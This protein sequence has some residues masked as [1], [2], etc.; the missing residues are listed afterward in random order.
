MSMSD[1]SFNIVP[2]GY[3]HCDSQYPAEVPRQPSWGNNKGYIEIKPEFQDKRLWHQLDGFSH[4]WVQFIFHKNT[5]W[6]PMTQPPYFEAEKVGTWASRSP[7]RPNRLGMSCLP[8]LKINNN[9]IFVEQ[10]DL[11]NGTPI[12]DIKPYVTQTDAFPDARMGWLQNMDRE[13][14]DV[15]IQPSATAKLTWLKQN[16]SIDFAGFIHT[17]LSHQPDDVRYKR[18]KKCVE[19]ENLVIS[20]RTWRIEYQIQD[21]KV[22]ILDISSGYTSQQ[23]S[24]QEDPIGDKDLHRK[25]L[26][27]EL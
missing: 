15:R 16:S 21:R 4:I 25:F 2:I 5:H 3:F 13:Q 1:E 20:H 14:Y 18:I 12:I 11:L 23:L 9:K 10:H 26:Q 7:Y 17:Q 22:E 27:A 6:K 24:E 19:N 8:L